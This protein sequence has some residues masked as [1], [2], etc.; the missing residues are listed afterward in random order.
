MTAHVEV[1]PE[2]LAWARGRAGS[3]GRHLERRF[4]NLWEWESGSR[5]PTFKQLEAFARATRT[6]VG[7]LFLDEPPDEKLPVPDY[8]TMRR[9]GVRRPSAD[10]LDT[11]YLCQQRQDW[12]REFAQLAGESPVG[13]VGSLSTATPVVEAAAQVRSALR[14]AVDERGQSWTEALRLLVDRAED[15][16]AL[17][18]VSGVVGSNTHRKLDPHEFRGF[19]LADSMAPVAFVNGADTKAAQLFTLVHELAHLWLG[20]PA[21]DD[22]DL[23]AA[24]TATED[25][26]C[27][28]VAAE[29]LVP[30]R[31]VEEQCD[32]NMPLEEE[33][34][35]LAQ[36]FK[37]STLVILRR[38]HDVGYFPDEESFRSAYE[39]ELQ[40]VL[41]IL[42]ERGGTG[43]NFYS[44]QPLRVSKRFARAVVTSALEGQ[45]LYRDAFQ[46][47]GFKRMATFNQL[48]VRLGMA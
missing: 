27:D 3:G 39:H 6:P 20:A 48:A 22:A 38:L 47:L 45:T 37:V 44:T 4:P 18:M 29:V 35:P 16:G 9:E 43:G 30:L 17:V 1:N 19:A 34:E 7:Y 15:V 21:L 33:L 24:P 10:L 14:F 25:R 40:H 36:R 46:M 8:R 42:G 12:F 23:T 28:E 2:L 31:E 26:W 5:S 13:M 11:I 32:K 41:G